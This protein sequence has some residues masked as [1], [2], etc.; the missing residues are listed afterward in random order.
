M[1]EQLVGAVYKINLHLN[2]PTASHQYRRFCIRIALV[3]L[4]LLRSKGSGDR[5]VWVRNGSKEMAPQVGL[6]S[7]VKHSFNNLERNGRRKD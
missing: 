1:A 4:K 3:G 2:I 7:K 6:E 5:E